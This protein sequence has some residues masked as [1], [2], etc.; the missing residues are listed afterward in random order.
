M[1]PS[2][3][4]KN[5]INVA[6]QIEIHTLKTPCGLTFFPHQRPKFFLFF[7]V[8]YFFLFV[9]ILEKCGQEKKKENYFRFLVVIAA[10]SL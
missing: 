4:C 7:S 8:K 1:P 10:S 5:L 6:Q 3:L 9:S 2:R